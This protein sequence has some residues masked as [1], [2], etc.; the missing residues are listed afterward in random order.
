[1][2]NIESIKAFFSSELVLILG[3]FLLLFVAIRKRKNTQPSPGVL[4]LI[5]LLLSL[6]ALVFTHFTD[7]VS[8]FSG[9]IALDPFGQFFKV[10]IISVAIVCVVMA[11]RSKD[12]VTM[13]RPEFYAFL[14]FLTLSLNILCVANHLLT[15]YLAV[16]M[17]SLVSY[18]LTIF[19]TDDSRSEEAGLKYVL[20][21][22]V[23][24][25]IMIFG[26]SLLYGLTGHLGL[27]EIRG[28]LEAGQ[29][30]PLVLFLA[31]IMIF[32]GL[33]YKMAIAPFHMWSP[34]VYEGA[35]MPVTAFLSVASKAGA[36]A[37]T[38]RF[39]L[40]AFSSMA[41]NDIWVALGKIDWPFLIAAL[42]ALTMTVGNVIALHQKNIKRFLA[43]SSIAHAGYL[44]MG[45]A[46]VSRIGVEAIMFYFVIYLLMNLGA[47]FVAT[48]IAN[49]FQT[50]NMEDYKG[51]VKQGSFG[52]FLAISMTI[53]LFSLTGIPPFAGFVAKWYIFQAVIDANLYWLAVV[54]VL[55]AG[56][57]LVYYVRLI[58]YM[59][60]DE[61]ASEMLVK[62]INSRYLSFVA[63]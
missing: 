56:I 2:T 15:I 44:L 63:V 39:F 43:Y 33:G 20:Y 34:D 36:F 32:A 60:I 11:S 10:I 40:V 5:T 21:G 28:V 4:A 38:L 54:G 27:A 58:K 41:G 25:G 12:I 49:Q 17:S 16:E 31:T 47:F 50:E 7:S 9:M 57:A 37:I 55:N 19:M 30:D 61:Q 51:L 59:I 35:P 14:L 6:F 26:M 46:A 13:P 53:F 22:G 1:M 3:I 29:A 42:S 24:S 52:T 18:M 45:V 48:I 62:N 23:A 8:L